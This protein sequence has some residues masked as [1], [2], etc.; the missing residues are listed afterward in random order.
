MLDSNT[1]VFHLGV[2]PEKRIKNDQN[3]IVRFST[4]LKKLENIRTKKTTLRAL[5]IPTIAL[6]YYLKSQASKEI[7]T[8][9]DSIFLDT[10]I[11]TQVIQA[12]LNKLELIGKIKIQSNYILK[13]ALK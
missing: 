1:I 13:I 11:P 6:Y 3:S 4:I 8:T 7:I 12:S 10:N 2:I 9:L 5:T